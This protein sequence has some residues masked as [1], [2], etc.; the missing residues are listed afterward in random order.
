MKRKMFLFL[1]APVLTAVLLAGPLAGLPAAAQ[2]YQ[3]KSIQFKVAPEY[4]HQELLAASGLEEGVSVSYSEMKAASQRL[5]DSH[6]FQEARFSY[7]GAD[8]VFTLVP[9]KALYSVRLENLP[10]VPGKALDAALHD[11]LPL[12]HGKVPAEGGLTEQVRQ[13]LE[14]LLA[15]KGIKATVAAAPFTD[16]KRVEVTAMSFSVTAPPVRVGEI[17]LE[18]VTPDLLDRARLVSDHARKT[19]YDTENAVGNIERAFASFFSDQGYAAAKVRA[20]QSG[21]PVVSGE[22]IEVPFTLTVEEG[23]LY[24]MGGIR[25]PSGELLTQA[26]INKAAGVVSNKV[27]NMSINGGVTLRAAVLYVA[28]QYRSKGYMDLIV[29]PH[30]EFDDAAG[31]VNYTMEVQPGAVYTMGKL[32]IQNGADDLRAAMLAAWKLPAGALF[33][34]EAIRTYFYA[35]GNTPLGRTFASAICRYTL[36]TNHETH[37]IDVTL[38]LERKP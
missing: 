22:A 10:L 27:E 29:T 26:E 20:E 11:R 14:E 12:Y 8:L 37:T 38:R 30:P 13:A 16:L 34:E 2:R 23:R 3:P 25:L 24:R 35:Q 21:N 9:S 17:H 18:G 33:N 5:L 28:G 7:N 19:G 31:I 4:S 1:T 32:T 6:L 36:F 15:A